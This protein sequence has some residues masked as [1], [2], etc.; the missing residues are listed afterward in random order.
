MPKK[1]SLNILKIFLYHK[2][3]GKGDSTLAFCIGT[4]TKTSL[5]FSPTT[6]V[7]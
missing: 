5:D 1:Y 4:H 6:E 3:Y 2:C 7:V